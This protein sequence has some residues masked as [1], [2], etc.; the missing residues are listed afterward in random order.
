[1][2]G[3]AVA[4]AVGALALLFCIPSGAER[5]RRDRP[6][7]DTVPVGL[8]G[9]GG[10][11]A[12]AS[13][14]HDPDL[15]FVSCDM[16]GFYRSTDGGKHWRMIDFRQTRGSTECRPVF[17]PRDPKTVYF[18]DL[19]SRDGGLTWRPLFEKPPWK[20]V[21]ELAVDCDDGGVLYV[22]APDG[23]YATFD[24]GK[25]VV[26]CEGIEG[27]VVGVFTDPSSPKGKKRRV[28]AGTDR[29]VFLS[30]DGGRTFRD[31]SAGLPWRGVRD[32]AFGVKRRKPVIYCTVPSRAV[33]G[34]FAGGVYRSD[35]LGKTWRP[36]MGRGINTRLGKVDRYGAGD[37]AQY[38]LL[39][40]A[41][42][43]PDLV[44]VTCRGTGYWPP[45]H[46]TVYRSSDGGRTWSPCYNRDFR[47]KKYP[48][49]AKGR[50]NVVNGWI[51]YS[52]SWIWGG[53]HTETGFFVNPAHPETLM[54]ADGGVL[55]VSGNGGE[56]WRQAYTEYAPNQKPPIPEPG[57]APGFW[58]SVGL[59]VTTCWQYVVDPFDHDR[60]YICYTD[61]GFALSTDGG[62]TWTDNSRSSGAPWLNTTYMLAFDPARKG[63]A[64]AA[65][66]SV[67]DIPSWLFVHERVSGSGGVCVTDDHCEHW[68]VSSNG[69]PDAPCT[70][71]ALDPKSPKD[72]RTLYAA[73]YGRGVY[74]SEDD[75]KS[76]KA[77]NNGLPL[78][79]NDHVFL[80]KV[81]PDGT[82]FCCITGRRVG[83][84]NSLSFPEPGGLF[85]SKDGGA[86][87]EDITA[88]LSLH[89]P[90]GFDF[91]P[92]DSDVI[93]LAAATIPH[94]PE[95]G[96]YRTTDGGK[97]WKRLLADRDFVG[98][99]GPSYVHGRF[100]AVNPRRPEQVF[101]STGAHGLW[102]STDGG[103]HWR[104]SE[105][106]P[107]AAINR[108]CFHP[109]EKDLVYVTTF[110]GGVFKMKTR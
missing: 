37:I 14:P 97:R 26:R 10:L 78:Q 50:L 17:H 93:Y 29:G 31:V 61:I 48:S 53:F 13:S 101:F 40:A 82:V 32:V 47:F 86:S 44:Y 15:M 51:P 12:P 79:R 66:S 60:H 42:E 104:Q 49:T 41:A 87:W 57:K 107:F 19:V 94:G 7:R 84:R 98:R 22:G 54:W 58:R 2:K 36:V 76:W 105:R 102:L 27:K 55:D 65:M 20:K 63:R 68:R 8:G 35:D 18:K 77:V 3:L 95:G 100:V 85:R 88:D 81:H 25:S 30:A 33:D 70:A 23:L 73:V 75:G 56:S 43:D 39:G 89:W 21:V 90:G 34:K 9:G 91:D 72:E 74:K 6:F 59:E 67:H 109:T 71:I 110:G 64:W 45:Y 52:L 28:V 4:A 83:P 108:V 80:V 38:Y 11:F 1:M 5:R 92:R 103:E 46:S 16:G 96:L 106:V 62:E 69:L 24:G 99:D